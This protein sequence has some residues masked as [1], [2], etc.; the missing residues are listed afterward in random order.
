M[1]SCN[2][3]SPTCTSKF[4]TVIWTHMLVLAAHVRQVK[5]KVGGTCGRLE[6]RLEIGKTMLD[7]RSD[8]FVCGVWQVGNDIIKTSSK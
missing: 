6:L 4:E 7:C 8:H 3:N 5:H 1:E 2:S